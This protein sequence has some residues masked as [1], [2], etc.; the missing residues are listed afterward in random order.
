MGVW[1]KAAPLGR[2]ELAGRGDDPSQGV[3]TSPS[4]FGICS[5]IRG[6][7][8]LADKAGLGCVEWVWECIAM[9]L[10]KRNLARKGGHWGG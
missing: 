4:L 1:G 9:G 2:N 8:A 3:I 10:I 5:L 7:A 6:T